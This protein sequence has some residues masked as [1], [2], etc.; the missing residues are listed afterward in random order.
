VRKSKEEAENTRRRI[1]SAAAAEFRER[2]IVATGFH[3]L[4]QAASLT[5]GGFYRHFDSKEQLVAEATDEA[6]A[7]L[8][9][10]IK[11]AA[12]RGRTKSKS[13]GGLSQAFLSCVRGIEAGCL[14]DD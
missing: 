12:G 2:G 7:A 1:V 8:I 11:D 5:H 4:M 10:R 14:D 3:D 9:K 6:L 13:R